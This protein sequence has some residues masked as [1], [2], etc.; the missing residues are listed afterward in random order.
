MSTYI[1][2]WQCRKCG[3]TVRTTQTHAGFWRGYG[4]RQLAEGPC[5]GGGDHDWHE[6]VK[7]VWVDDD[8]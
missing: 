7:G 8:E 2:T 1:T 3:A 4:T 5:P 6:L